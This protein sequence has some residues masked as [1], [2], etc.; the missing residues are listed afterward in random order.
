[1]VDSE[2]GADH[3]APAGP[4]APATTTAVE[5]YCRS[6]D[7][8]LMTRRR[9]EPSPRSTP[10]ACR[11]GCARARCSM[12]SRPRRTSI[13]RQRTL[14]SASGHGRGA[15]GAPIDSRSLACD[16]NARRLPNIWPQRSGACLLRHCPTQSD[17]SCGIGTVPVYGLYDN[18]PDLNHRYTASLATRDQLRA[19]GGAPKAWAR[20][21]SSCARRRRRA[22]RLSQ[23]LSAARAVAN[24]ATC[25]VLP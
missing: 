4:N 14:C 10:A 12:S 22:A 23:I 9:H 2:F 11:A 19:A 6:A 5:F 24:R 15:A 21:A 17:G 20:W 7:R 1:M 16:A 25:I 3:G 18:R 8:Y 13:P